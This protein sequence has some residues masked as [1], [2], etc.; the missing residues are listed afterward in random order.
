MRTVNIPVFVPHKGCP[1]DCVFCNQKKITGKDDITPS[2]AEEYIKE[3]INTVPKDALCQIAFFGGSFTAIEKKLQEEFLRAAYPY[4]ESGKVSGIRISTRPDCIDKDNLQ[5]LKSYGVCAIE[6]GAQSTDDEV[7]R[8]ANRGHSFRDIQT[9][10]KLIKEFDCFELGLQMMTGLSGDTLEKTL[11]TA[12]DIIDLKA[13][14]TRIYPTLVIEN[15]R[16][17]DMY[18][19]GDYEPLSL[20]DA[21]E[22]CALVYEMFLKANVKVLRMGLMS[23]EEIRENSSS[24]LAGPVHSSFGELVY[25]KMF[26]NKMQKYAQNRKNICV[27]VNPKDVSKAL[28]NKKSNIHYLKDKFG[29]DVKIVSRDDIAKN[30]LK[31]AEEEKC[32]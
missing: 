10:A 24:V 32:I 2:K 13:D 31:I 27:C 8:L 14:T 29:C 6:L 3:C 4:V 25:S 15:S 16:L 21:V 18:R 22:R 17:A 5:M 9:A 23:S 19:N 30:E 12:Q 28:G 20:E 1:N 11:K 26:L 7:L